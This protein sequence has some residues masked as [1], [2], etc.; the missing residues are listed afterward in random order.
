MSLGEESGVRKEPGSLDPKVL[1]PNPHAVESQV[2]DT[3]SV[4][5]ST[6]QVLGPCAVMPR[7]G[8]ETSSF[9][10]RLVMFEDYHGSGPS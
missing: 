6:R 10:G 9:A 1:T 4:N 5:L 7:Q 2:L 3:L 8:W